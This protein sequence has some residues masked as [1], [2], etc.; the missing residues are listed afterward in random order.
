LEFDVIS[1]D[2]LAH[3]GSFDSHPFIGRLYTAQPQLATALTR[4]QPSPRARW[5]LLVQIFD[6]F[7]ALGLYRP[8]F[9]LFLL[10]LRASLR[11][12][13]VTLPRRARVI[14]GVLPGFER[15]NGREKHVLGKEAV[16]VQRGQ[17]PHQ[18]VQCRH[19]QRGGKP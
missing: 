11:A 4:R 6:K 1:P 2:F 9:R 15:R 12:Y 14:V 10:G 13:V 5:I 19:W 7:F 17:R 18:R 3:C 8:A 16:S